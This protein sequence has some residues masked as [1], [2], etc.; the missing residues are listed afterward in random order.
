MVRVARR[1]GV[2][3][4]VLAIEDLSSVEGTYDGALSNF[5]ALNCVDE[6]RRL[7]LPMNRLI[8]PGGYLAICVMGR[9]CLWETIWFLARGQVRNA[10]RR[11][12]GVSRSASLRLAV[13]YPT[14]GQIRKAF[15]PGFA[16]VGSAGI[17]VSVPP[18]YVRSL[19][20][21]LLAR[22][23]AFD[24]HIAHRPFFRTLSDHR[25]LVFVRK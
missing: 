11:W 17:G 19:P 23:D 14:V 2:D 15:A 22:F 9:F 4:S 7:R 12:N 1:R 24:R 16:L 6:L 21:A 13:H 8:R 5:G 18:S 20:A 3:A 10:S 25:L